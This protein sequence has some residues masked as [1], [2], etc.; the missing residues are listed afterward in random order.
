MKTEQIILDKYIYTLIYRQIIMQ[1]TVLFK[2]ERSD[3]ENLIQINAKKHINTC[4][5]ILKLH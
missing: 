2:N 1:H 5:L 3:F 4:R